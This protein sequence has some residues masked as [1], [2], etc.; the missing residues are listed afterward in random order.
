MRITSRD[1]NTEQTA[2]MQNREQAGLDC[3]HAA[4]KSAFCV[5]P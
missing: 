2:M 1:I 5:F 3:G 4:L